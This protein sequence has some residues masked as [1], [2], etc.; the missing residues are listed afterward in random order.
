MNFDVFPN[1]NDNAKVVFEQLFPEVVVHYSLSFHKESQNH[2]GVSVTQ[3]VTIEHFT[4]LCGILASH[5]Y[6]L[7]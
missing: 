6:G 5:P 2:L 7:S 4:K 1:H 3:L